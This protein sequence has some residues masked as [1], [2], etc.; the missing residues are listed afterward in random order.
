MEAA[1]LSNEDSPALKICIYYARLLYWLQAG[2][3]L[4]LERVVSV[5]SC[6][7]GVNF[8]LERT[9]RGARRLTIGDYCSPID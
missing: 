7:K 9:R 5:I 2:S 1:T 4:A 6:D 3:L 8:A